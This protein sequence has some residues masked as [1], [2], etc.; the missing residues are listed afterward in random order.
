MIPDI[1]RIV[2]DYLRGHDAVAALIG[3]RV[4]GK[5]PE[6]TDTAWVRLTV[7]NAPSLPS[8]PVDHLIAFLAQLD[9]YAGKTGGQPE[10]ILIGRTV[11]AA[12]DA[13][14]GQFAGA[15]V[16]AVRFTGMQRLPDEAW[17]PTRERMILTATIYAHAA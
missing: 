5:T 14:A 8:S 7:L 11:R 2:G 13:M 17:T 4:V 12:L 10:A 1:E 9:C 16:T 15:V 3:R 6:T